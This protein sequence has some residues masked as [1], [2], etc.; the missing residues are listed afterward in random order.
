MTRWK[1]R[2]DIKYSLILILVFSVFLYF[3]W[4]EDV[5]SKTT[6][7]QIAFRQAILHLA[8]TL[9][10]EHKLP[11]TLPDS[12]DGGFVIADPYDQKS[13]GEK[14]LKCY[15]DLDNLN[16]EVHSFTFTGNKF[17]YLRLSDTLAVVYSYGP[18]RDDDIG[19]LPREEQIKLATE[20]HD[21]NSRYA[22]LRYDPTNGNISGGDIWRSTANITPKA[23]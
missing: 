15:A 1:P 10:S 21:L 5:R 2:E 19:R 17:K 22:H 9:E 11:E 3:V 8:T 18:D 12:V 13:R 7:V 4:E 14:R 23:K 20:T 6:F 16:G